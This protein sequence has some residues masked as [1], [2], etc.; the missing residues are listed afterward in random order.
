MTEKLNE[1]ISEINKAGQVVDQQVS[2]ILEH[3]KRF[4]DMEKSA[5]KSGQL[6]GKEMEELMA[7]MKEAE[8]MFDKYNIE[9]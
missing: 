8:R 6:D 9:Y 7:N 3:M 1:A 4:Y 2:E 5:L